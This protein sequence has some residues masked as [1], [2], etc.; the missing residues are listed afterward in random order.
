VK[1]RKAA[2]ESS[3][4]SK[5]LTGLCS[6]WALGLRARGAGG[7]GGV[8]LSGGGGAGNPGHNGS[9]GAGGNGM[10]GGLFV[11]SDSTILTHLANTLMALNSLTAGRYGTASGP[12]ISGKVTSGDHDL[13]GDASGSNLSSSD[14]YGDLAGYTA[15][16]LYLGPLANNGG[17]LAGAPGS[18]QVVQTMAL[19]AGSPAIDA[20]DT[21]AAVSAV[22]ERGYARIVGNAIDIGAYEYGATPATTDLSI[23]G[24]APSTALL[25]GTISYTLTVTNNSL[26]TAQ[27]NVTLSDLMPADTTLQSWT[28]ASSNSASLTLFSGS[29]GTVSALI[30]SLAAN[31][32]ASFILVVRTPNDTPISSVFTD[33]ASAGPITGDPN[34]NNNSASFDTV[35]LGPTT[36]S[37]SAPP[38]IYSNNA[39]VT[40][41]V[42]SPAGSPTGYVALTVSNATSSTTYDSG[43]L[44][45]GVATFSIPG[46]SLGN[47]NL[48]ATYVPAG[49][50]ASSSATGNLS[51][52]TL[53]SVSTTDELIAAINAAN[54]AGRPTT[55]ALTP[56]NTLD[57]TSAYN[58]TANAL[59]AITGNITVIGNG[60]TIGRTGSNAFRLFD[61]AKGASLTLENMTLQG[62]LA[63]GTGAAA[64][65]GAI[66]SSGTLALGGVTVQNNKAQGGTGAHGGNAGSFAHAGNGSDGNA[67]LGG[68]L[69]VAGGAVTL[70]NDTFSS[71][72]AVGGNGG[73]G[74]N[75]K[76][77]AYGGSGGSGGVGWGGGVYVAAGTAMLNN[78][79][80][81]GNAAQG[82]AGGNGG[83]AETFGSA[84]NGNTGGIGSGGGLYV[85]GGA[86]TL[87]NDTLASNQ[88]V[89]G[90]GGNGGVIITDGSGHNSGQG[91]NGG[92]GGGGSGGGLYVAGGAVTLNNNTVSGNQAAGSS[93]GGGGHGGAFGVNGHGGSGGNATGGG[94]GIGSSAQAS[95]VNTLIA[96]NSLTGATT[97]APDVS[98]TVH[99]SDH[100]LIGDGSGSNL[101]N[102]DSGGDLVGYTAA[103]LALGPLADN[104]G[105][106]QTMALLPG[107]PAIDAGDGTT[108]NLPSTDQRGYARI[109]GNAID[110]GAVEY[111]YDL[112]ISGSAP[113][114]VTSGQTIAYQ[115]TVQNNGPDIAGNGGGVELLDTLPGGT[116]FVSL[117]APSGWSVTTPSVGGTGEVEAVLPTLA[118]GASATFTLTVQTS[119]PGTINN[120]FNLD[121]TTWD[122]KVANNSVSFRTDA[123]P[124]ITSVSSTTANGTYG[125]GSVIN[126]SVNFSGPV[127]V[128]GT[129]Q[130]A[131]NSGGTATYTSGSGTN[132]LTF[133]Y[134]V[135]AGQSSSRLDEASASALTLNG[136][137]IQDGG[138]NAVGLTLPS[139][140]STGSLGANADIVIDAIAPTVVSF[141]VLFGKESYN[142]IGSTRYD[143]P[144]AITGIQVVFSKPIY[145]GDLNSLTGLTATSFS[146]LGTTTLTWTFNAITLGKF[147]T[148]LQ[149][150]GSDALKDAAGNPLAYGAGFAQNFNVLEGDVNDDGVVDSA[151]ML[152]VYEATNKPYDIFDDI[153]GDGVV[154][155]ADV[156]LVRQ[157]I[158]NQLS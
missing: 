132:T 120:T 11:V 38:T 41:T 140:G 121:P 55:I 16:Q 150:S 54:A 136:G 77:F 7:S 72:Q 92:S 37:I 126:L 23:S 103:Q 27:S 19:L 156:S 46:L 45:G 90:K 52:F 147:A 115:L 30:P 63:L 84:G 18:Q 60:D 59:P 33:T 111:Q 47:Y 35:I 20:G 58:G 73:A 129:P 12:D 142:L 101:S 75:A 48:S 74:G 21:S 89:G 82:G 43:S 17:P 110:I 112:S 15:A 64:E 88:T 9:N 40:V 155:M 113:S 3:P 133:T 56:G 153:N 117:S 71:D 154:T 80:L 104:G 105:P 134:T 61:V 78:D 83:N 34:P 70:S 102:G 127:T 62:G 131:L 65:G 28:S 87:N 114:S 141:N 6:A 122:N 10:G 139:P 57:Y 24:S 91:G 67:G 50:F 128:S 124:A 130:L 119:T 25:G 4:P 66:Y 100:D 138:G 123:M 146:G 39:L 2:G 106:T 137:T 97:T 8:P 158:G 36:T 107:S 109:V 31:S 157:L 152:T 79:T 149:G 26:T 143:L 51:V 32:S 86:V 95:L 108:A 81:S 96:A 125:V 1:Q 94:L 76:L 14:G 68:G 29:G 116:T 151:D 53:S 118:S 22:D 85:A 99:S 5:A 69:Y 93:G 144:W 145:S 135:A 44:S 98:G 148:T 42:T 13:I 49:D